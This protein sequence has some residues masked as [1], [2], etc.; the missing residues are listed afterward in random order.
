MTSKITGGPTENIFS[1]TLLNKYS[2][3]YFRCIETGFIQTEKPY[4]L[5]EAYSSAITKLDVG[6]VLR[7]E[8]LREKT[9][10]IITE[11]LDGEGK[12]LDYAGGYGLFTRMM[13]DRGFDFYHTDPFCEN[14]FAEFFDLASL[15]K[16]VRFE[17]VT[18]FE[19]LEHLEDP[20]EKIEE[21]LHATDNFLFTTEMQPDD[22]A[23]NKDWWYF[24]QETGQHIALYTVKSLQYIADKLGYFFYTDGQ[25]I[26]LFT[27][28]ALKS[29]PFIK[30]I[31]KEPTFLIKSMK[32]KVDRYF[33][34][35]II[36][37][38]ESLIHHDWQLIKNKLKS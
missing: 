22:I 37:E 34:L 32:R 17:L 13:R 14:I 30:I 18:A 7:N 5:E 12:F 26:H 20:L 27:K 2:V 4:W 9:I 6:L 8:L 25:S 3:N 10:E 11:H 36:P 19:V 21:I 35:K 1:K 29:D 33:D 16:D 31:K 23:D 24:S 28:K 38:R 15:D